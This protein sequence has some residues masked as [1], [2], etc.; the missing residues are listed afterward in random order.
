MFSISWNN[1]VGGCTSVVFCFDFWLCEDR[2]QPGM[3]WAVSEKT[4][5]APQQWP[6][7]LSLSSSSSSAV[8]TVP[9]W[10]RRH[11]SQSHLRRPTHWTC[12]PR[13]W[14]SRVER[15]WPVARIWTE[16]RKKVGLPV[17]GPV[18]GSMQQEQ[19]QWS[20]QAAPSNSTPSCRHIGPCR[21]LCRACVTHNP[22]HSALL[23]QLLHPWALHKS[24]DLT[25]F[26]LL[27]LQMSY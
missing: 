15:L 23:Q 21:V 14:G 11:A 25:L 26:C 27:L 7:L 6:Q 20:S 8:A 19:S 16:D 10:P 12:P 9:T 24:F 13:W 17:A 4:H 1:I 18:A 5:N 2:S 22:L 3:G